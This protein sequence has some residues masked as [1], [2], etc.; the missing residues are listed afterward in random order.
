MPPSCQGDGEGFQRGS[1]KV[2]GGTGDISRAIAKRSIRAREERED[3]A[4]RLGEPDEFPK[5]TASFAGSVRPGGQ[6][7]PLEEDRGVVGGKS[8]YC[9]TGWV[10]ELANEG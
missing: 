9:A 1:G 2:G 4:T 3:T 6:R 7:E 10:D 5:E 8:G